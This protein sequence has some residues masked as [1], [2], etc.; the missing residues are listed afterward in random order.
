[1]EASGDI[2]VDGLVDGGHLNAG[3]NVTVAG[4]VIGHGSLQAAG[5]VHVRFAEGATVVAGTLVVVSDMVI[6]SRLESLQQIL[7]GTGAPRR[8]RMIGGSAT[9]GSLLRVPLLGTPKSILAKVSLGVNPDLD[10]KLADVMQHIDSEKASEAG[11]DKLARQLKST[12]DPQHLLDKVNAS[13]QH[14]VQEW[15]KSLEEKAD[16]EKEI[17]RER[18]ARLEVTVGVEGPVDLAI[19][20]V[21]GRLRREFG[22]GS[23]TLNDD[24]KIVYCGTDGS[25]PEP[26]F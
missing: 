10:A 9:A 14:V 16:I 21:H 1:V 2:L 20:T 5:A 11:L 26:V 4:G 19:F 23:F 25:K 3:G 24:D 12:G 6:D 13:R 15:G 17:A 18:S 8:G 7:I 22:P